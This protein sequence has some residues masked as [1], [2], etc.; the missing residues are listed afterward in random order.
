MNF[1]IREARKNSEQKLIVLAVGKLTTVAQT[2]EK[3]PGIAQQIRLV[4]VWDP[5]ILTLE[6][7]KKDNDTVAMNYALNKN[8]PF[9]M[10]NVRYGKTSGTAAATATK[11]E[12]MRKMPG[13]GPEIDTP[14]E[15][16]H[17]VLF[18]NF[19]DYSVNLF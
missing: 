16:R 14:V 10:V 7:I 9:D 17:G 15:G 11:N 18:S 1:I 2:L 4:L 8:V 6:S 5:I 3:D 13:L 12:V 19:G